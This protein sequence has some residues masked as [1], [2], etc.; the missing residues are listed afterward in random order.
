MK[1]RAF[2]L[3]E[4]LVVISI[5]AL[6]I[7]L[8]L[9][10]LARARESAQRIQC[11]SQLKS[12]G[13]AMV[14]YANDYRGVIAK[15]DYGRQDSDTSWQGVTNHIGN[16]R[17]AGDEKKTIYHGGWLING[18][19]ANASS[20]F[21]P[22]MQVLKDDSF[23]SY[24][25]KKSLYLN[26]YSQTFASGGIT[27]QS[28]GTNWRPWMNQSYNIQ[29]I[30]VPSDPAVTASGWP[31]YK[32]KGKGI[33]GR[34]YQ[35]FASSWPILADMRGGGMDGA[36]TA[37]HRSLGYNVL[38]GDASAKFLNVADIVRGAN[39]P[40]IVGSAPQLKLNPGSLPEDPRDD[41]AAWDNNFAGRSNTL[42]RGYQFWNAM[43]GAL[44]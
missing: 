3:V 16:S 2:T 4:L 33:T 34:R 10:A 17:A 39:R 31:L 20:F 7:A 9:P 6:L 15:T 32:L 25:V 24:S 30:L 1:P 11:A 19:L 40:E 27:P 43:Y 23:I 14:M 18:Y 38:R 29:G 21:C 44:K 8:L 5:I 22:G 41:E 12:N 37:N 28:G 42:A 36:V 26:E 35:E 13:I